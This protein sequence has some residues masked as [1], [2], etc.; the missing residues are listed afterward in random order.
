MVFIVRTKGSAETP[1]PLGKVIKAADFWAMCEA[2]EMVEDAVRRHDEIIA[3]AKA[4]Y[5]AEQRRGYEE[6]NQQ[7]RL[8]QSR[9]MI[10]LATQTVEYFARIESQMV[11]LVL[12]A[13][14][15]I[16]SGYDDR[17]RVIEAVRTCL[18]AV[19]SQKQLKLRVHP[20]Q[21]GIVKA[22]LDPLLRQ[23]PDVSSV[24]VVGDRSLARDTCAVESGIGTVEASMTA[25]VEV[26]RESLRKAFETP[27]RQ[28]R[29]DAQPAL[30]TQSFHPRTMV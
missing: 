2:R 6:G 7:A 16:V 17:D 27:S 21:V 26:L 29:Q 10:E 14:R 4:A 15:H 20:A 18:A 11:D 22:S 3:R 12:D 23:Y 28:V 30:E 25:Q 1:E 24:D 13:M 5:L 9:K 8:E 19:R